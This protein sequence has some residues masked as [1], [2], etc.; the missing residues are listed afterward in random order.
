MRL[1]GAALTCA[2]AST[3]APGAARAQAP[4]GPDPPSGAVASLVESPMTA[5]P[6]SLVI[7]STARGEVL[8]RLQDGE[9][10]IPEE[11][12]HA[13][14]LRAPG[15]TTRMIDG[16]RHLAL[17][18]LSSVLSF[19]VDERALTLRI[20]A[21]PAVLEAT[22]LDLGRE[23]LRADAGAAQSAF[24]NYA[25]RVDDFAHPSLFL[26]AGLALGDFA[27]GTTAAITEAGPRRGL[28]SL[29][30]DDRPRRMRWTLGDAPI[31]G[32]ALGSG[33]LTAGLTLER[34]FELE[35]QGAIMPL[36]SIVAEVL[37]PST[38]EVYVNG[39]LVRQQQV[40]AGP[41]IVDNIPATAGAG[42][43]R[44]VLRD[45]FGR[46]RTA[47][48]GTY[49]SAGLLREGLSAF[50]YSVGLRRERVAEESFDYREFAAFARH[51][52]GVASFLTAGAEAEASPT[53]FR[54]GPQ[55]TVA[56]PIGQFDAEL[57][58]SLANGDAG[59]FASG[60]AYAAYAY[61]GRH[62]GVRMSVRAFG[63]DF[64]SVGFGRD[65]D[66]SSLLAE[67][68]ASASLAEPVTV[69]VLARA[70][71]RRDAGAAFRLG[72]SAGFQLSSDLTIHAQAGR[73]VMAD[74][75]APFDVFTTLTWTF[76]RDA[77]ASVGA[78]VRDETTEL[79]GEVARA[80]PRGEGW[81]ARARQGLVDGT[82]QLAAEA[83]AQTSFGRYR[84]TGELLGDRRHLGLEAAG[85]LVYV[86]GAG[87]FITRPIEG[88]FA[89]VRVPGVG[90]VRAYAE[91]QEM[92]RTDADGDL[93][94][95]ELVPYY[96]NRLSIA[97]ED[98]PMDRSVE[99]TERVVAPRDR[100]GAIA[101]FDAPRVRF[102]RG[103]IT[104]ARTNG[105]VVP[106]YG[107]LEVRTSRGTS[108]SPLSASGEFE[109]EGIAAGRYPAS[110]TWEGGSCAFSMVVHERD[111]A[112]FDLGAI[113]CGRRSAAPK[114]L[115]VPRDRDVPSR[116]GKQ[117]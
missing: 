109:L 33:Y 117:P 22:R 84:A 80:M 63:D 35:P 49:L 81:G 50:T 8:V 57:T 73:S 18:S 104:V 95:T 65:T 64:S 70:D 52:V 11:A 31:T 38:L 54:A 87:G 14:G 71:L 39:R 17:R 47:S 72:G 29:S 7:N 5:A 28:S 51:R 41:L 60:G 3:T 48:A 115:K 79:Y 56:T 30:L 92:G 75:S 67:L 12:L 34:R 112:I 94:V 37:T 66:R 19:A 27:L 85:G 106:A 46:E 23:V 69:G 113:V 83:R 6:L 25:A 86:A 43:L 110:V 111:G 114:A 91:N 1:L 101:I 105:D 42:E 9:V 78:G 97:V 62:G 107:E 77:N 74:G 2:L 82:P 45:A 89:V 93:L 58:M 24:L 99:L 88:S 16:A 108:T 13:A 53:T 44:Y 36:P 98:L 102:V 103:K 55:A 40:A 90:G 15:G 10:W 61:A 26:E 32:G 68:A 4:A 21:A 20:V 59:E 100:G 96:G 116:G 76:A